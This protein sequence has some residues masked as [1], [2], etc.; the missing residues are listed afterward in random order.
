MNTQIHDWTITDPS[1]SSYTPPTDMT[2][3]CGSKIA[4]GLDNL[5]KKMSISKTFTKSDAH[6]LLYIL[7]II[8]LSIYW[9]FL[10]NLFYW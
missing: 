6:C 5:S 8:N 9:S 4:G 1:D 7:V 3:I 10:Y 2:S